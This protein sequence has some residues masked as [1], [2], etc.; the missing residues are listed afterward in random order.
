MDSRA[1]ALLLG[2]AVLAAAVASGSCDGEEDVGPGSP[3]TG[4]LP[5]ELKFDVPSEV[6]VGE[7]VPFRLTVTNAGEEPLELGLG[8]VNDGYAANY[9]FYIETADGEEVTC[10]LCANRAANPVLS[11][12]TLQP[13][14]ELELVWAWDQTDNDL[15]PAP[16][17]TYSV[18][19]TFNA[20]AG[21]EEE[22][23]IQ[24]EVDIDMETERRELVI[25][26]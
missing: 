6:R 16:P 26:P 13:G 14:E 2:L 19:G 10:K 18:Y 21:S 9:N 24:S 15:Q 1:F 8:D 22:F 12:R 7:S 11:F 3:D 20:G 4:S 5:L 25:A 23:D 17:G